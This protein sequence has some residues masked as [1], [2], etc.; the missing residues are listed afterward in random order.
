MAIPV[1]TRTVLEA[2]RD[3][4]KVLYWEPQVSTV[5]VDTAVDADLYRLAIGN[6][7]IDYT[8]TA[9]DTPSTIAAALALAA[10]NTTARGFYGLVSAVAVGAVITFTGGPA[11]FTLDK[12]GSSTPGNLTIATPTTASREMYMR[13]EVAPPFAIAEVLRHMTTYPFAVVSAA[14]SVPAYEETNEIED[15]S[16]AVTVINRRPRDSVHDA[17]VQ[18]EE[19]LSEMSDRIRFDLVR[20]YDFPGGAIS[21]VSTGAEAATQKPNDPTGYTGKSI[22]FTVRHPYVGR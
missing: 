20:A 17:D 1:P 7:R 19:G 5:T 14:G 18:D 2:I 13:V 9:L 11:P 15:L 6:G 22:L 16:L 10:S 4:L 3:R 12:S 8:A 21:W